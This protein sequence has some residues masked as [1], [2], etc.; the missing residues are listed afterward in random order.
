MKALFSYFHCLWVLKK[1]KLFIK[2]HTQP[3]NLFIFSNINDEVS[4]PKKCNFIGYE[5]NLS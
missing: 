1:Y 3:L 2:Y 4:H 5:I